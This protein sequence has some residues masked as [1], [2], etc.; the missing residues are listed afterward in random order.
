MRTYLNCVVP[1]VLVLVLG[2]AA[3]TRWMDPFRIFSAPGAHTGMEVNQRFWKTRRIL[4][5]SPPYTGFI[6]GDSRAA[7]L[8][9]SALN[10]DDIRFFNYATPSEPIDE[11][12]EKL[13]FLLDRPVP[14]REIVL[15][16]RLGS[17]YPH[18]PRTIP[19]DL[20]QL[21][22]PALSGISRLDFYARF[23]LSKAVLDECFREPEPSG[24]ERHDISHA[25][26]GT[27]RYSWTLSPA[28][29]TAAVS[30]PSPAPTPESLENELTTHRL[31]AGALVRHKIRLVVVVPPMLQSPAHPI[32]P[33]IPAYL[34]T[35]G[36]LYGHPPIIDT[37]PAI[38]SE[39]R[40]WNDPTHASQSA[41]ERFFL[42]RIQTALNAPRSD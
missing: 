9:A 41:L 39:T 30:R 31:I 38:L 14:P 24:A 4:E 1:F 32:A 25:P 17:P 10:H 8:P 3:F 7:Q 11:S 5:S 36:Q 42:P 13:R 23:L 33:G 12:L 16:T 19:N 6:L 20:S 35:L 18:Q 15:F 28:Q 26:D 27:L 40:Y 2:T 34:Q 22:H 29:L 37:D 21:D